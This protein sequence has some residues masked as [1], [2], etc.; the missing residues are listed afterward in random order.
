MSLQD[1]CNWF[2]DYS[3]SFFSNGFNPS[4][5]PIFARWSHS[6]KNFMILRDFLRQNETKKTWMDSVIH[7][8]IDII[9]TK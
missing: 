7:R 8:L 4:A 3:T 1:T 5:I 6:Q 2:V 9:A